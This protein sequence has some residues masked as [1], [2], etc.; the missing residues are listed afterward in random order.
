MA[1]SLNSGHG[2]RW[3]VESPIMKRDRSAHERPS[4]SV[5]VLNCGQSCP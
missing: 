3:P 4:P 5:L 1:T 2:K